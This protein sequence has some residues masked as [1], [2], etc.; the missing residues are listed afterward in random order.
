MTLVETM[1]EKVVFIRRISKIGNRMTI[2]V[3]KEIWNK[4]QHGKF[5]R[6]ILEPLEDE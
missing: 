3:P 5:Y 1:K 6:V 2:T 4:I